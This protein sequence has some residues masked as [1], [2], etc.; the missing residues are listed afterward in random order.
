MY[1]T[2]AEMPGDM[3]M[4]DHLRNDAILHRLEV[5]EA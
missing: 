1:K 3:T 4:R 5:T 2:I